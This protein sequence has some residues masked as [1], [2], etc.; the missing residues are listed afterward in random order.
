M[1][2]ARVY[3]EVSYHV[4]KNKGAED[5]AGDRHDVF[6]EYVAEPH[7]AYLRWFGAGGFRR[8]GGGAHRLLSVNGDGFP[9]S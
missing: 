5:Y 9:H 7:G 6:G 2:G 8:L 3:L 4:Y 1:F